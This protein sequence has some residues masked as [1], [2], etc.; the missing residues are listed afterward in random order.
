MASNVGE[1]IRLRVVT[2]AVMGIW[3]NKVFVLFF[4]ILSHEFQGEVCSINL[5]QFFIMTKK[6]WDFK[7]A[8]FRLKLFKMDLQELR[9]PSSP[10]NTGNCKILWTVTKP[11]KTWH[12]CV[13]E[14][15]PTVWGLNASRCHIAKHLQSK[16][17]K[18]GSHPLKNPVAVRAPP[19][20]AADQLL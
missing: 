17:Y 5:Y 6:A 2:V 12:Y 13:A 3:L 7:P 4:L 18:I 15:A 9:L 11:A 10:G 16:R 1:K 20:S 8:G 19:H 14:P